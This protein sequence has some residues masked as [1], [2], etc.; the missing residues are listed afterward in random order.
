MNIEGIELI[1]K[2][3]ANKEWKQTCI[4]Y[5]NTEIESAIRLH[6]TSTNL[7]KKKLFPELIEE[8]KSNFYVLD[9]IG[10]VIIISWE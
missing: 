5:V 10:D 1:T 3:K 8:L 9:D 4:N 7:S 6:Y 2:E